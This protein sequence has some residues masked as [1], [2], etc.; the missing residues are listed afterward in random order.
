MP[1]PRAYTPRVP[2]TCLICGKIT[3]RRPCEPRKYCSQRCH[4]IARRGAGT[5]GKVSRPCKRC[6]STLTNYPSQIGVYCSK[7]CCDQHKTSDPL[8]R[9]MTFVNKTDTCWIWTGSLSRTGYGSFWMRGDNYIAHRAAYMLFV[10]DV[11]DD[12]FVCH[13][14]DTPACVNPDHLFL[15][16]AQDNSQDM[17]NKGRSM[18]GRRRPRGEIKRGDQHWTHIYGTSRLPRGAS[19]PLSKLT[20]DDVRDIRTRR[21]G[22]CGLKE[23]AAEYGITATNIS[24]I[25]RRKTWKHV[26]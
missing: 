6:G 2:A 13:C 12:L 17:V 24:Y 14:C 22:G 15:G 8:T 18:K 4:G 19:H 9:L 7:Y 26:A 16:T 21:D 20:D 11:P 23:L 5:V 10:G 3:M 25:A 1:M